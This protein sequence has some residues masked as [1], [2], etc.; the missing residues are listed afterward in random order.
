MQSVLKQTCSQQTKNELR[1][2]LYHQMMILLFI[3]GL[4]CSL[5][6]YETVSVIIY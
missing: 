5:L 3:I 6:A 1:K 2:Q 4:A